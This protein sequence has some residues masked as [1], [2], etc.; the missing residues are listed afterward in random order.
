MESTPL[1]P[2]LRSMGVALSAE[3]LSA[4]S[5]RGLANLASDLQSST[6]YRG[7][8]RLATALYVLATEIRQDSLIAEKQETLFDII[9][10]GA[11]NDD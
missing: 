2:L 3:N 9:P 11:H 1:I 4:D 6:G 8:G 7:L 5:V 10:E